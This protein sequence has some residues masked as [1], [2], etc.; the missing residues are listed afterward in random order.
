MNPFH[1]PMMCLRLSNLTLSVSAGAEESVPLVS[2]NETWNAYAHRN[3]FV[4]G[5]LV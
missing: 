2:Q 4:S 1:Y 5:D 3:Y